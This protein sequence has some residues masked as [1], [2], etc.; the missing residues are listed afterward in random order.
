MSR[1]LLLVPA[2]LAAALTCSAAAG[3]VVPA[4]LDV[5]SSTTVADTGDWAVFSD[6]YRFIGCSDDEI[7]RIPWY[8]GTYGIS[9]SDCLSV[10][11][12]A[13]WA[14]RPL[15]TAFADFTGPCHR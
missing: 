15:W 12:V 3:A 1:L 8:Q 13:R 2:C 4:S 5:S 6:Y 11:Y 9:D 14:G 10:C 7:Y